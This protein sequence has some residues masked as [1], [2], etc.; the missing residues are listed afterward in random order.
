[1]RVYTKPICEPHAVHARSNF[2]II[3][4]P[5]RAT[6]KCRDINLVPCIFRFFFFANFLASNWRAWNRGIRTSQLLIRLI[7]FVQEV[8]HIV[9]SGSNLLWSCLIVVFLRLV[10]LLA[11]ALRSMEGSALLQHTA[12]T[13]GMHQP[14]L[15]EK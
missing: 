6:I 12:T 13:G 4:E 3:A 11:K 10:A 15:S 7:R 5:I 1:M 8:Q 9:V 2:R 14:I